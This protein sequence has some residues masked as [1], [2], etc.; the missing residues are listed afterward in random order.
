MLNAEEEYY[1]NATVKIID[2]AK[3]NKLD[4]EDVTKEWENLIREV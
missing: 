3:E 1:N 4:L 2:H